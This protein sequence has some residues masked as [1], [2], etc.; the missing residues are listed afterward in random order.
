LLTVADRLTSATSGQLE[1]HLLPHRAAEPVGQV[2]HLVHHDV[3]EPV[4]LP[5]PRVDHVAQHLGGHHH[6]LGVAVDAGVAGEQ[7]DRPGAVAGDEVGVLLVAQR[8]DRGGVE[9]PQVLG[10]GEVDGELADD[11]LPG[12]GGGAH[13]HPVAVFQRRTGGALEGVEGEREGAGELG[14]AGAG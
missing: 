13:E 4:E 11:G 10:E 1:D 3:A 7:A 12:P 14:E 5:G 6:H 8:L 2:V 9:A